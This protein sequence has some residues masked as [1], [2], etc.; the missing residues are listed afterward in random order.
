MSELTGLEIAGA[1]QL[2][3]ATAAAEAV[4]PAVRAPHRRSSKVAVDRD[5]FRQTAAV[6][7]GRSEGLSRAVPVDVADT[8]S[9]ISMDSRVCWC[10]T[11][12]ASGR[13]LPVDRYRQLGQQIHEAGGLFIMIADLLACT[14]LVPPGQLGADIAAGTTQRFGVPMNGGGP[15]AGYI[16]TTKA[17]GVQLPGRRSWC[18]A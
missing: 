15:H 13:V 14:V 1:S 6:L 16:A 3:E 5:I 18:V 10:N 17:R 11:R 7:A 12:G 4:A 9:W 2:D 8:T